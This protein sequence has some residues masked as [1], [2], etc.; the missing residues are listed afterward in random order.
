MP[1]SH[2]PSP[3][4]R[5]SNHKCRA[6]RRGI[7]FKLTFKEW[8]KIWKRSGHFEER[9]RLAHEYHMARHNDRGPYAVGNVKIITASQNASEVK[10]KN[11]RKLPPVSEE[12][13]R[14]M[15]KAHSGKRATAE[16][17]RKLSVIR[18]GRKL[19]LSPKERLRRSRRMI[20]LLSSKRFRAKLIAA[21]WP[22]H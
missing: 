19:N 22:N 8:M 3:R 13:R 18:L 5:Y 6:K 15:S 20:K 7:G 12:T 14:K 9:G 11:G 1:H 2:I 4:D 21:R 16:T 17:R 10:G